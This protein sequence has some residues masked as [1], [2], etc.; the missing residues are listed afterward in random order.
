MISVEPISDFIH[1]ME[2]EGVKPV[3]PIA[4][5]LASGELIRFR[6][7]GDG[8]G[9]QNGWAILYLDDRP[10][11]A[12]GNYRLG[13]SRKWR[14]DSDRT[15]TAEEREALQREWTAAKARRLEERDRSQA[16]AAHDA[17]E[18]WKTAGPAQADHGYIERKRL[19]PAPLRQL[20]EQLLIP[21]YDVEGRLWNVQRI[22]PDGRKRFLRGGRTDGLFC[23][24]AA[25]Q[26]T[27]TLC[28]GEGYSTMSA[29]TRNGGHPSLVTFSSG[30]LL[31]VAR[32]WNYL[33]PDLEYIVC[34]D[35]DPELVDNPHVRKNV[36][37]EAATAA[38]IEIGARL[39][40]PPRKAA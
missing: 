11:G 24:I 37:I 5:R 21:M 10:A 15:L 39:A 27:R 8:K 7:D 36:G 4:Q 40:L 6:C 14:V 3:E 23:L 28:I 22:W 38:A 17:A 25:D 32:M 30:N 20:G 16:E 2:L 19:D 31:T 34:A 18:M 12:F 29:V 13:I 35:D 1:A 33:R 9:R 26:L